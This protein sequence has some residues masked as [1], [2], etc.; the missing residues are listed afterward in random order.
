MFE[1]FLC[2]NDVDGGNSDIVK[3]KVKWILC[4]LMIRI[5]KIFVIE[6]MIF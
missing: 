5:M 3:D 4:R 1:V 2:D 6:R